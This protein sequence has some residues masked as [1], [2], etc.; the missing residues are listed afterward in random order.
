M[1]ERGTPSLSRARRRWRWRS[2]DAGVPGEAA[3]LETPRRQPGEVELAGRAVAREARG[4]VMV[5]VPAVA[6][7]EP[8]QPRQVPALV[9]PGEALGS[10]AVAERVHRE[11]EVV[12]QHGAHREAPD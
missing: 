12:E 2:R 11:G 5:V 7:R 9:A 3:A 4:G 8:R 6:E 1:R 10:E